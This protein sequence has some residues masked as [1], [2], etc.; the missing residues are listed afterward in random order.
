MLNKRV[1]T[2]LAVLITVALVVGIWSTTAFAQEGSGNANFIFVNFIGQEMTFDLDDVTYV[3][4]GTDTMPD[5]GRLELQLQA[6]E[7]KYAAN[8][9]G[10]EGS[11]GEFTIVPGEI[12]ARAA[13][14][15]QTSPRVDDNGI[16]LEKPRDFVF[17]F[18]FD[19]F[20]EPVE[21]TSIIDDWQPTI[22]SPGSASIVWINH[23][24]EE[25]T[26]DLNGQLYKISPQSNNIPGRLQ[27]EVTPGNYRYTASVPAGSFN[28]EFTAIAGQVVGLAIYADPLPEPEYNVGEEF[29]FVQ[30]VTM[31]LFEEDLTGRAQAATEP[32]TPDTAPAT[33]PAT[34]GEIGPAI[35]EPPLLYEGLLV[36]NY[37]GDTLIF[38]INNQAYSVPDNTEQTLSLPPGHYSY[39]AS[40]PFVA[41]TGELDLGAGQGVELSIAINVAHDFLTVYQN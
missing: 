38:T 3:I 21:E 16:L 40:L 18:D 29:E 9:P 6:G 1:V 32:V 11:A 33:L 15:E 13:R 27:I 19:P 35:V 22:A 7:H 10:G 17:V 41:T 23:I 37:T 30:P 31:H 39:T 4:P 24:G 28:S 36:K 8:I 5:G 26:V 14:I 20:A 12:V 25:L 2:G 34:G